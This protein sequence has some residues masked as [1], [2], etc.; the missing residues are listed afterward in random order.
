MIFPFEKFIKGAIHK[1]RRPHFVYFDQF[2]H[3]ITKLLL[4]PNRFFWIIVYGCRLEDYTENQINN[5]SHSKN[6]GH[7]AEKIFLCLDS[8]SLITFRKVNRLWYKMFSNLNFWLKRCSLQSEHGFYSFSDDI[9]EA[10]IHILRQMNSGRSQYIFLLHLIRM[11]HN[12]IEGMLLQESRF[13]FR[14]WGGS[15]FL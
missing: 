1:Q 5:R 9:K 11:H 6:L 15:K 3:N 7:V 13:H 10:W 12:Q 2:P 14:K 8:K 4:K